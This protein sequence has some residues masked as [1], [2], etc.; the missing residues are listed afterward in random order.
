MF[1]SNTFGALAMDESSPSASGS[2]VR[3][4]EETDVDVGGGN[5]VA[6]GS[7]LSLSSR[8]TRSMCAYRTRSILAL[9]RA[10]AVCWR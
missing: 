6:N 7:G 10:S 1:S 2:Q 4:G 5:V 3:E 9:S 8:I